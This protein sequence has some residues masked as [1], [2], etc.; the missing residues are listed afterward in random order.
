M[1]LDVF[2]WGGVGIRFGSMHQPLVILKNAPPL[3]KAKSGGARDG[4][5][6]NSLGDMIDGMQ[7][8]C[9]AQRF[10]VFPSSG[11]QIYIPIR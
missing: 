8:D 5:I 10:F 7:R 11:G 6:F 9:F 2:W 3:P 4:P 1:V